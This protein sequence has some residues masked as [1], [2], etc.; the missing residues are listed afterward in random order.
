[1]SCVA[2]PFCNPSR[3]RSCGCLYDPPPPSPPPPLPPLRLAL[4][5]ATVNVSKAETAAAIESDGA[6]RVS[7]AAVNGPDS[8][9][10]SGP[11]RLVEGVAAVALSLGSANA[12]RSSDDDDDHAVG[13]PQCPWSPD[14]D[15]SQTLSNVAVTGTLSEVAGGG[16]AGSSGFSTCHVSLLART[17]ECVADGIIGKEQDLG[18]LDGSESTGSMSPS[19]DSDAGADGSSESGGSSSDGPL[20]DGPL[21]AGGS[22]VVSSG[23]SVLLAVEDDRT[24]IENEQVSNKPVSPKSEPQRND[25]RADSQLRIA[26][27]YTTDVINGQASDNER[28]DGGVHGNCSDNPEAIDG[29]THL[30][31]GKASDINREDAYGPNTNRHTINGHKTNGQMVNDDQKTNGDASNNNNNN[32]DSRT[33][34]NS[35]PFSPPLGTESE[36]RNLCLPADRFRL[37]RGV[38]RA[39]HSPAMSEA[40]AGVVAAASRLVLYNPTIPLASNVTGKLAAAG[41]LTDPAYWGK[42]VLA[43]VRFYDGLQSLTTSKPATGNNDHDR[44][45]A[46]SQTRNQQQK[47]QLSD[48]ACGTVDGRVSPSD[49]VVVAGNIHIHTFVEVGP[50]ALLCGM[51]RRA[52]REAEA[53]K[54]FNNNNGLDS[55]VYPRRWIAAMSHEDR[56]AGMSGLGH[57]VGAVRGVHYH[58]R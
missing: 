7:L 10:L 3:K 8:V 5:R 32:N 22:P 33:S 4:P 36:Y 46:Q 35:P 25:G 50:S 37:L 9:V 48:K 31:D 39:F 14:S 41:E 29:M 28:S 40:A 51:G 17:Q 43:T 24:T 42:Q 23:R 56:G 54:T 19:S 21:S 18:G 34:Q 16:A 47:Q 55:V 44:F 38:S 12:V 13:L 2:N 26:V 1:M 53:G 30:T 11:R 57:V 58:R 27:G 52:F 6:G 15:M 20:S 49:A 45:N